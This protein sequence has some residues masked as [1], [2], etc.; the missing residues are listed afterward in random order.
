MSQSEEDLRSRGATDP[1]RLKAFHPTVN[2][3]ARLGRM[4]ERQRRKTYI[5]FQIRPSQVITNSSQLNQ[6]DLAKRNIRYHALI[7]R[8]ICIQ[9]LI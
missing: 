2:S 4:L 8:E 3:L 1:R 9:A 6:H 5:S 7:I